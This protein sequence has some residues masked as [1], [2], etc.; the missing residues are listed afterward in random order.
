MRLQVGAVH[1]GLIVDSR[2]LQRGPLGSF[3]YVVK[4]DDTVEM[5]E[6]EPGQDY[7]G[8]LLV[9]KGLNAGERVVVDGQLRLQDGSK[10]T[11]AVPDKPM[12]TGGLD[13]TRPTTAQ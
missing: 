6:I 7:R 13:A 11:Q 1:G 4:A 2:A 3:A 9:T 8:A 10:V 5:R 12:Q